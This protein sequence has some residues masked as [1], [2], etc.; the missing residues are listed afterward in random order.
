MREGGIGRELDGVKERGGGKGR[1]K[2]RE[3]E[4]IPGLEEGK[5]WGSPELHPPLLH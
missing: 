4:R 2:E 3:R 5:G 1:G